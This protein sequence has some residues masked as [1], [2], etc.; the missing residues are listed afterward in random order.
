M[1]PISESLLLKVQQNCIEN[2][3]FFSSWLSIC[4][5]S[6]KFARAIFSCTLWIAHSLDSNPTQP[7]YRNFS[8]LSR[9]FLSIT[10]PSDYVFSLVLATVLVLDK[11]TVSIHAPFF[12]LPVLILCWHSCVCELL[13]KNKKLF[14]EKKKKKGSR[15]ML[16]LLL[17]FQ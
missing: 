6:A 12:F 2:A 16:C 5:K 3:I 14:S 9:P 4:P 1:L 13:N 11:M 15:I 17:Q 10:F 8:T 7:R